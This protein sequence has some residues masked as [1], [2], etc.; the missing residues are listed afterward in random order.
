MNENQILS[1]FRLL[2]VRYLLVN[3]TILKNRNFFYQSSYF[4]KE[5]VTRPNLIW[6]GELI[7]ERSEYTH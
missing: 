7:Y 3:L 4:F 1:C 6:V 5:I 2:L